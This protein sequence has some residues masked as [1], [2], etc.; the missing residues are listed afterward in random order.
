MNDVKVSANE[1]AN[2]SPLHAQ[3]P[4]LNVRF[5]TGIPQ[6]ESPSRARIPGSGFPDHS[7][8]SP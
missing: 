2:V 4:V 8:H 7:T 1:F 6:A 5:S 3:C